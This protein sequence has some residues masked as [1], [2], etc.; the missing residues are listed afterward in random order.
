MP[1]ERTQRRRQQ[2]GPTDGDDQRQSFLER[3][4]PVKWVLTGMAC[5]VVVMAAIVLTVFLVD[6]RDDARR[7][8]EAGAMSSAEFSSPYDFSELPAEVDLDRISDAAFVSIF[9]ESETGEPTS[10]GMSSQL[11]DVRA[12]MEAVRDADETT[13]E[14]P[15]T[16]AAASEGGAA[17]VST[18][19]ITFVFANRDTLTFVIDMEQGLL[20]RGERAFAPEGDLRSLMEAAIAGGS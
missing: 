6:R 19:T 8:A 11:P 1:D 13:A 17:T 12:L 7:A 16:A 20:L 4:V 18:P 14:T 9:V 15:A 5:L 2:T 10:Y 3:R